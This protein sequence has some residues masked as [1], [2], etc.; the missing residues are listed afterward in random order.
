MGRLESDGMGTEKR[1]Y[2]NSEFAID[3]GG[4]G[5]CGILFHRTRIIGKDR[6]S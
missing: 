2:R 1:K 6:L 3:R 5:V 4:G